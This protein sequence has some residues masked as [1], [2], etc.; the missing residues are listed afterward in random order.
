MIYERTIQELID[1]WKVKDGRDCANYTY[2]ILSDERIDSES[3]QPLYANPDYC[4]NETWRNITHQCKYGYFGF[5]SLGKKAK[6]KYLKSAHYYTFRDSIDINMYLSKSKRAQYFRILEDSLWGF[7]FDYNELKDANCPYVEFDIDNDTATEI[8]TKYSLIRYCWERP[9]IPTMIVEFTKEGLSNDESI[10][11][12]HYLY[13]YIWDGMTNHN[14]FGGQS[15]QNT[16]IRLKDR[17][18]QMTKEKPLR[19]TTEVDVHHVHHFLHSYESN[20]SIL[21]MTVQKALQYFGF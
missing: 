4:V 5:A 10:V 8:L 17:L 20:Y 16:I 7:L 9:F 14:I 1:N 3:F 2:G 15:F 13:N 21:Q 12:S 6:Q 11:L 18:V 19:K